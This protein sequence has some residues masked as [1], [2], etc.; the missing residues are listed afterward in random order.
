MSGSELSDAMDSAEV[1]PRE[2]AGGKR[3]AASKAKFKFVSLA[4]LRLCTVF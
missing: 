2:R 3:A 1:A 4:D